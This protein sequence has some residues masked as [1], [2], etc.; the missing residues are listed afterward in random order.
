MNFRNSN[1][2]ITDAT[3][4]GFKATA[5]GFSDGNTNN[6]LYGLAFI[7]TMNS[8][9]NIDEDLSKIL[10]LDKKNKNDKNKSATID[11]KLTE[12]L[13]TITK[14]LD[15]I[16]A[17]V[18]NTKDAQILMARVN[19]EEK[20][21]DKYPNLDEDAMHKVFART[22]QLRKAGKKVTLSDVAKQVSDEVV[23][24]VSKIERDFAEKHGIDYEKV[25]TKDSEDD[26]EKDFLTEEGMTKL[27]SGKKI[28][29][30]PK[31]KDKEV[32]PLDAVK[33]LDKL[34]PLF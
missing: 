2:N 18:T 4:T 5:Q 20:L 32:T 10:D 19:Q 26:A 33:N 11:D 24:T 17:E 14:R 13:G 23:S 16:E 34:N 22:A 1:Y 29:L 7:G 8:D 15:G 25:I 28:S 31:N 21:R 6:D 30:F 12:L 9:D 3:Y 27:T